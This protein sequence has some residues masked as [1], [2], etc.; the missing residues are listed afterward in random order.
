VLSVDNTPWLG[1]IYFGLKV[2]VLLIVQ[3]WVRATLPRFRYDRLMQ[4]GWKILL[5]LSLAWVMVTA[6]IVLLRG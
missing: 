4:F 1:L 3:V 5:P 6:F 2:I